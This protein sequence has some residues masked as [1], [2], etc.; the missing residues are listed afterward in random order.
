MSDRGFPDPGWISERILLTASPSMN[1]CIAFWRTYGPLNALR[2][3]MPKLGLRQIE[4]DTTRM[5]WPYYAEASAAYLQRPHT[6]R[7]IAFMDD[8]T[9]NGLPTWID[10]DD[11]LWEVPRYNPRRPYYTRSVLDGAQIACTRAY[12]ITVSTPRLG[13]LIQAKV[14]PD[15]RIYVT[16]NALQ[17]WYTLNRLPREKIVFWRGGDNHQGDVLSVADELVEVLCENPEWK[18]ITIGHEPSFVT[19]RVPQAEHFD[20]MMIP[21]FHHWLRHVCRASVMV[22]P[23]IQNEFN[24][25]KSNIAWLEATFGGALCIGPDMPEW[26]VPGCMTYR[27]GEFA[28]ALRTAIA[29]TPDDREAMVDA[30]RRELEARYRVDVPNAVRY[31]VLKTMIDY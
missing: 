17:N 18:L 7:H 3:S 9:M 23:L 25:C 15:A 2:Q 29:M 10:H 1:D 14:A 5:H 30:S 20:H 6:G 11:W 4:I 12:A 19:E 31:Q 28:K 27:P 13:E 26:K 8:C 21:A 22:V 16:R 24:R